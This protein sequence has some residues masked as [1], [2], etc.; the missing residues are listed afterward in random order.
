MPQQTAAAYYRR[1]T[2]KQ[3]DSIKAQKEELTRFAHEHRY[4]VVA[5]YE[6]DGI[7]GADT[8]ARK[9]FQ[10]MLA[11]AASGM[12]QRILVRDLDRFSRAEPGKTIGLLESLRGS[13][14]R[15]VT[16]RRGEI[17][18]TEEGDFWA[19]VSDALANSRYVKKLS[20]GVIG[21]MVR[22][23]LTYRG[24][25]GGPPPFG[26]R[27]DY[28]S[29]DGKEV[30]FLVPDPKESPLVREMFERYADGK[31]SLKGLAMWL[32]SR[33][34][35]RKARKKGAKRSHWAVCTVR[36]IL[37]N[38]VYL[39][40]TVYNRRRYGLCNRIGKTGDKAQPIPLDKPQGKMEGN[41]AR[42][43]F[44]E[45]NTHEALVKEPVFARVQVVLKERRRPD[46]GES[47]QASSSYRASCTPHQDGGRFLLSGKIRCMNCGYLMSGRTSHEKD[48]QPV[49]A[50][51]CSGA[52]NHGKSVCR[53]R[54]VV[55]EPLLNFIG[56][57]LIHELTMVPEKRKEWESRLRAALEAAVQS[58]P[59]D[60][61]AARG[62]LK[63]L[64]RDIGQAMKNLLTTTNAS[65]KDRAERM[66]ADWE[67]EKKAMEASLVEAEQV[68]R[69]KEG[70]DGQVARALRKLEEMTM[71]LTGPDGFDR[72]TV[73]TFVD[74]VELWFRDEPWITKEGKPVIRNGERVIHSVFK[75]GKVFYNGGALCDL[76]PANLN[77]ESSTADGR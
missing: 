18:L 31:A 27:I 72:E 3:E 54:R 22:H 11:D 49:I 19:A 62:R 35:P 7:S 26:Y 47:N 25:P 6:D 43:W 48:G 60:A 16:S 20:Q 67:S 24:W 29:T 2:R 45:K 10:R 58:V 76:L 4:R 66:V 14:C 65:V 17:N 73:Q 68:V 38:P 71:F 55:Q 77:A 44:T 59:V 53:Y 46:K 64:E 30:P 74:R 1:S 52:A 75:K 36:Q 50:Y 28:R 56:G 51:Y 23:V 40:N 9:G 33:I 69:L 21:G 41:A 8:E 13:G 61:K 5:E 15:V 70:I 12:F 63:A 57:D 37:T 34:A 39:G 32:E 42:D